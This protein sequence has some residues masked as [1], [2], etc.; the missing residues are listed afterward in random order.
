MNSSLFS[1]LADS[2]EKA[3]P[4]WVVKSFPI[5]KLVLVSLILVCS[6]FMIIAVVCQDGNTN[7][8][9]GITADTSD[10]FYNRNKGQSMQGKIKKWMV[11]DAIAIVVLCIAY[12]ILNTIYSGGL[13]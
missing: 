1:L 10:T 2:A 4:D 13:V 3:R 6:I 7:G 9:T 5:I 8:M 11:I 12:L